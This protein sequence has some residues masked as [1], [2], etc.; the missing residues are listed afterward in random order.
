MR[1]DGLYSAVHTFSG[2]CVKSKLGTCGRH[3]SL[4][5]SRL[6]IK[7]VIIGANQEAVRHTLQFFPDNIILYRYQMNDEPSNIVGWAYFCSPSLRKG[8]RESIFRT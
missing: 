8:E 3:T 7:L 5:K 4:V 2:T 6:S 1:E